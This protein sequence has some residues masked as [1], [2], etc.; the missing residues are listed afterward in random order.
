[1][2]LT[3]ALQK[4]IDL[5]NKYIKFAQKHDI[6]GRGYFGSTM[7]SVLT[8]PH[9]ITVSPTGRSVTVRYKDAYWKK[10]THSESFNTN[11]EYRVSDLRYEISNYIIKAIKNGAKEEGIS[12]PKTLSNPAPAKNSRGPYPK[13][14]K[15]RGEGLNE[16]N[17]GVRH[18][19]RGDIRRARREYEDAFI[20]MHG[21]DPY[22]SREVL[23]SFETMGHEDFR[24]MVAKELRRRAKVEGVKYTILEPR[25]SPFKSNPTKRKNSPNDNRI[26]REHALA[27]EGLI[28]QVHAGEREPFPFPIKLYLLAIR[29]RDWDGKEYQIEQDREA[30]IEARQILIQEVGRLRARGI[31]PYKKSN[32]RKRKNAGLNIVTVKFKNSKYNYETEVSPNTTAKSAYEYF[33]GQSFD[34]GSYPRENIQRVIGID[35]NGKPVAATRRK[36]GSKS[37]HGFRHPKGKHKAKSWDRIMRDYDKNRDYDKKH[38]AN[39][40]MLAEALGRPESVLKELRSL[41]RRTDRS[42]FDV[43]TMQR[44]HKLTKG[45]YA[46]AMKHMKA[47]KSR[48]RKNPDHKGEVNPYSKRYTYMDFT[49]KFWGKDWRTVPRDIRLSFWD[50]FKLAFVGG[51]QKYKK[52]TRG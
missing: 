16:Y 28:A 50:D 43:D 3:K 17:A 40:L 34:M 24:L 48:K 29:A 31:S 14:R 12:I 45:D 33:V 1:M 39:F 26:P 10:E 44:Q 42:G 9:L 7:E 51:L 22:G 47:E 21:A 27:A 23:R 13:G 25:R 20:A 19:E 5:A 52:E 18:Q 35:F 37:S 2:A 15:P 4:R 41:K 32:P 46:R 30:A 6:L 8:Y 11:D 49:K 38:S 36:N